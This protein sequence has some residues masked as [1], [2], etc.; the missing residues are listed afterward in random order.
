MLKGCSW[1]TNIGK[2]ILMSANW[3]YMVHDED[4]SYSSMDSEDG[5][6]VSPDEPPVLGRNETNI[7]EDDS[8]HPGEPG[9]LTP[10]AL[11]CSVILDV[12]IELNK[13]DSS[14]V[15][16]MME[17]NIKVSKGSEEDIFLS[18]MIDEEPVR[19]KF[20]VMSPD[21]SLKIFPRAWGVVSATSDN[22]AAQAQ[23][24]LESCR[25]HRSCE[26]DG[27]FQPTRL[28]D[29]R[30][31]QHLRLVTRDDVTLPCLYATLS[32]V[33]GPAQS[34][35]LTKD[36]C[37]QMHAKLDSLKMGKTINDSIMVTRR[38]GF[39]YLW[40]DALCIIQDSTEDKLKE[41]SSM[42]DIYRKSALT[43]VAASA[44]S[45][46]DGFLHTPEPPTFFVEPFQIKIKSDQGQLAT[47]I[48]GYRETYRTAVD[49]I[50]SRAWTLQ[51][52]VLSPRLLIFS[53]SGVMW[54]CRESHTNPSGPTDG[55]PPYQTSLDLDT[56]DKKTDEDRLREQWMSIRADYSEMDISYCSD[57]LP[58]ISA[59]AAE[60]SRRT[61]WT[62]LAGMWK[63][64]LF[65]EL[66][67]RSMRQTPAGENFLLKPQKVREAGYIAPSWS[68]AST[69][70]GMIV[71]GEDERDDREV[72]DFKVLDRHVVPVGESDFQFG[73][74]KSGFLVVQGKIVELPFRLE[75]WQNPGE[76]DL[77]LLD[78]RGDECGKPQVIG[79]GTLDPLDDVLPP[80]S[81]VFCLG[82]SRLM[83]GEQ[84]NFP[85]DGL[86][87][88]PTGSVDTF[89]RAGLF[90]MNAPSVFDNVHPRVIR[91]E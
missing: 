85:I 76:S 26:S 65:S 4:R 42:S 52:R 69:G 44:S 32:Y 54:M 28:I 46:S 51:E 50:N 7:E 82:M 24:W 45:A 15:F 61:E 30:N 58:A 81:K 71:D 60:L 79:E 73:P 8:N 23:S 84:Q 29:V 1:C 77:S 21:I 91:I 33:W 35:T 25:E 6:M 68:W 11:D 74:V 78:I 86:L 57:K 18:E 38:M 20:E 16:N 63:E 72:F 48:C 10:K 70:L 62:Y 14:L 87:L 55:G 17:V 12:T 59:L 19:I 56:D 27:S 75:D 39:A 41:L 89:R 9:S 31:P 2:A 47:L 49:P 3:D 37:S 22:W 88:L 53:K 36:T 13:W 43:I 40:I 5:E 64:N 34:Y 80:D 66:H 90:R 83:L 67:W